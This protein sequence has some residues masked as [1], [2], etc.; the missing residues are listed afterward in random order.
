MDTLDRRPVNSHVST[1]VSKKVDD[2]LAAYMSEP[3]DVPVITSAPQD[4]LFHIVFHISYFSVYKIKY[5]YFV[6]YRHF[7]PRSESAHSHF[8][9]V[10]FSSSFTVICCLLCYQTTYSGTM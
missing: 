8:L 3:E 6:N 4:V 5:E 9:N 7:L 10:H 2:I 1:D